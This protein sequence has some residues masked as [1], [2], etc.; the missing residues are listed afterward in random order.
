MNLMNFNEFYEFDEFS[1]TKLV[2][3]DGSEFDDD[4]VAYIDKFNAGLIEWVPP[5]ATRHLDHG[6]FLM[7]DKMTGLPTVSSKL[8]NKANVYY[9][10]YSNEHHSHLHVLQ[11]Y[12]LAQGH[13]LY[14][15]G[16]CSLS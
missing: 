4:G 2:D 16:Y 7:K 15:R 6:Y 3:P 9:Y 13:Q 12:L 8:I 10:S 1:P 14:Q 11:Y 5:S